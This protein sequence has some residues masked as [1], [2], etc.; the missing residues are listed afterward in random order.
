LIAPSAVRAAPLGEQWHNPSSSGLVSIKPRLLHRYDATAAALPNPGVC[1][2]LSLSQ[3]AKPAK[4]EKGLILGATGVTG[5]LAVQ[6][7]PLAEIEKVWQR[8][9]NGR[10]RLV[11][12][13]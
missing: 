9:E 12:I 10:R 8:P 13:P 5:K 11:V 7:V 2:L 4:G 3:R 1:A 6:T